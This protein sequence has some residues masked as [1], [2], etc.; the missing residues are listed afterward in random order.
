MDWGDLSTTRGQVIGG[1]YRL[2]EPL[3]HAVCRAFCLQDRTNVRVYRLERD[4]LTFD[5]EHPPTP[6]H[7]WMAP[8]LAGGV[9]DERWA[10]VV[11]PQPEG[12]CID[13]L[14]EDGPLPLHQALQVLQNLAI[15]GRRLHEQG[16]LW[17]DL[18]TR[19]LYLATSWQDDDSVVCPA[20]PDLLGPAV[21]RHLGGYCSP[22]AVRA[23]NRDPDHRADQFCLGVIG[24]ELLTGTTPHN[25]EAPPGDRTQMPIFPHAR[26][27]ERV[28]ALLQRLLD[29]SPSNRFEDDDALIRALQRLSQ[30]LAPSN[31][32][33]QF[34]PV[35]LP[36]RATRMD[37]ASIPPIQDLDDGDSGRW[38]ENLAYLV[39][40]L[41]AFV[42]A[43][44]TSTFAVLAFW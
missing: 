14:L 25:P 8:I 13:D 26:I 31:A 37:P 7:P 6:P 39:L 32:Y 12:P 38:D 20:H 2:E 35:I 27:P 33:G 17:L 42:T 40:L 18:R 22:E 36:K 1:R 28:Q 34:T 21:G 30:E 9:L 43:L 44:A 19:D 3:G 10:W 23:Y 4:A 29:P 16:L 24:F 5:P 41:I 15:I 11:C